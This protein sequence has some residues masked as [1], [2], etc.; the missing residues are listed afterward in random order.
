MDTAA[1]LKKMGI[2][3][4]Q[5]VLIIN[6]PARYQEKTNALPV[7][8][9]L[10][11]CPQG[12]YDGAHLFVQNAIELEE[13]IGKTLASIP[14]DGLFWL[15]FPKKNANPQTDLSR[16]IVWDRLEKFGLQPVAQVSIDENWTAIQFRPIARVYYQNMMA[17]AMVSCARP[18]RIPPQNT[19]QATICFRD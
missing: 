12:G 3:T 11:P 6:A 17:V 2:R 7:G 19:T 16:E 8:I 1:L 14:Y 5:H 4:G 18:N 9:E 10:A 15:S 13:L